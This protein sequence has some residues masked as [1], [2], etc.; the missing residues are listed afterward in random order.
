M[1]IEQGGKH[2]CF[3]HII[4]LHNISTTSALKS[5]PTLHSRRPDGWQ[6]DGMPSR[7]R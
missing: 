3:I 6:E 4:L 7:S 2:T 1:G 5:K